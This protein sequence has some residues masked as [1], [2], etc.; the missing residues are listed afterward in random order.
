MSANGDLTLQ[1]PPA[2]TTPTSRPVRPT[3]CT[4]AICSSTA[5][6]VND[7][8]TGGNTTGW[9]RAEKALAAVDAQTRIV[10]GHGP[11]G[12]R[13]AQRYRTMLAV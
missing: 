12:D 4:S 13:A 9:W 10:L 3:C 1:I 5:L 2:H 8:S 11:L 6:P 7:A